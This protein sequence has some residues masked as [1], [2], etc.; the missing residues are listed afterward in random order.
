MEK[1][2]P[3]AG[4]EYLPETMTSPAAAPP[5]AGIVPTSD[6]RADERAVLDAVRRGLPIGRCVLAVS[7]GLDSAVLLDAAAR[8]RPSCDLVVA[9][10]D[11]GTGP[12]ARDAVSLVERRA[13]ALGLRVIAGRAAAPLRGEAEW[14]AARW[15][16]LREVAREPG[17]TVATA[18]TR[19]DQVE[20]VA[21]RILRDAGARGLAALAARG[22]GIVRPLLDLRR[23]A[24]E[25]YAARRDV[26]Y[27]IDPSNASPEHARN[28]VRH[29]LLPA[30]RRV[31][32]SIDDELA[33]IGARAA[34]WRAG[35]DA[36]A[37]TIAERDPRGGVR[38]ARHSMAGYDAHS[39]AIVWPAVAALAGV[40]LDRRG[41]RR[42]A[43]FTRIARTG[44]RVP[45]SGGA[46]AVRERDGWWIG[47]PPVRADDVVEGAGEQERDLVDGALV[48]GWRFSCIAAG[49][50]R[51][52]NEPADRWCTTLP[53]AARLTVRA[54]RAGD[55]LAGGA[56]APSRRVKRWLADAR[57]A[58]A[59]RQG[60]PVV[61]VDG[62][63]VWIPGVRRS[64]AASVR[65]GRPGLRYLC[66]RNL[67]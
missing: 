32:P 1:G 60:W 67:R 41:T 20:T 9:T 49:E 7:G 27:V 52:A 2:A 25:R 31:R 48:G 16:F 3:R 42:L 15:E 65:S 29:D 10:F 36:L 63:I 50:S 54:W 57:I 61:L 43:T 4:R 66:E 18:H 28:R 33:A 34:A 47:R 6:A 51:D 23:A 19:D 55:R 13:A 14:R 12:A 44:A 22:E 38:V 35:A 30:M 46:M 56:G 5:D 21:L 64:D 45:L 62:E 11:H 59:E 39:M 40:T 26:A 58:S 8:V 24:L 37:A 17:G 53:S